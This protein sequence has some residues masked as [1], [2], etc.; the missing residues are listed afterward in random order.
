MLVLGGNSDRTQT[1]DNK[2]Y[3]GQPFNPQSEIRNPQF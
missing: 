3:H 1:K 2:K